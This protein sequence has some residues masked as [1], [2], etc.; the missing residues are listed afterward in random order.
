MTSWRSSLI[1][2]GAGFI[3]T[4]LARSLLSADPA[5]RVVQTWIGGRSAWQEPDADVGSAT[6]GNS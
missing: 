3:G 4:H 5:A 1:L 6:A 2:G